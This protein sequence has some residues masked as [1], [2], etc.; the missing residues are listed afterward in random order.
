MSCAVFNEGDVIEL[1]LIDSG[2]LNSPLLLHY[3]MMDI[4][5]INAAKW[6]DSA[7]TIIIKIIQCLLKHILHIA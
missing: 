1:E 6:K 3:V 7:N 4:N 5:N 2:E